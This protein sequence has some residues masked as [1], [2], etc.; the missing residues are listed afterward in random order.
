[1]EI[2]DSYFK[3]YTNMARVYNIAMLYLD[4]F[5][6]NL[7]DWDYEKDHLIKNQKRIKR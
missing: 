3:I 5:I 6:L 4:L 7:Y 2:S 1:M